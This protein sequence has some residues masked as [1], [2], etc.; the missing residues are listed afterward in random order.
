[1]TP[2]LSI[3]IPT[4]N[5]ADILDRTLKSIVKEEVFRE[6]TDIEIVISDNCSPDNTKEVVEKYLSKFPDKI[7]YVR[8]EN[9]IKDKNFA[10]VLGYANGT[11]AKL[12]ND[13]L[14]VN[15]DGLTELVEILKANEDRSVVFFVEIK[16]GEKASFEKCSNIEMFFDKVSYRATWIGGL[17]V[18]SELYK[19]I[20]NPA[21]FSS[22]NFSQIDIITRMLAKNSA[23]LIVYSSFFEVQQLN[24]KGGYNVAEVF[25][26]NLI[27]ILYSLKE[28]EYISQKV[29]DKI[30]KSVLKK[31][32]NF[33]Y[34]DVK[35]QYNFNKSGY[36]KF[37]FKYYKKYPYF[38]IN[39]LKYQ[40]LKLK[41]FIYRKEDFNTKKIVTILGFIKFKSKINLKKKWKAKNRH[42]FTTLSNYYNFDNIIVG[43][44]TYGQINASLFSP[45][46][47]K[48][49]IGN[50]CS[51]GG[52]VKF[53]VAAEHDYKNLS[54]YPFK[55]MLGGCETEA[56]SKG[57]IVVE[58][59]VWIGNNALILSGVTIGQG[60]VVAAGSV[61]TKDIEPY[62][63]VAGNP[64]K[65]I[66]YRFEPEIIEKLKRIDYSKLTKE[67]ALSVLPQLYTNL[68][69]EN[70]DKILKE[71]EN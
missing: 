54:S 65:V 33:Y 51:I 42:N 11:F 26:T 43:K 8:Q 14:L 6:T 70:V 18:N 47:E 59:D 21:R 7:K 62:A 5:R 57:D 64:A 67:K 46:N 45:T 28:E 40:L 12:H 50:Y 13:T 53:I 38:Y 3:C 52:D 69:T 15:K 20:E 66:K 61:V 10:T 29:V 22:L 2:I 49:Y 23:S 35:K 24:N 56:L 36:F 63:I 16:K 30:K 44:Y 37:L 32:I 41:Y 71:V 58:D 4:Y 1:M 68:T 27:K 39:Y 48:L 25:G 31:V 9:N 17:C 34:F 60:A 55:V 19:T